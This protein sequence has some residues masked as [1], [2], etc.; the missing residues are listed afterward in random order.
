VPDSADVTLVLRL[1]AAAVL[2]A[3]IGYEREAAG[4]SAGLR[5]HMLVAMSA[6][7]FVVLGEQAVEHFG[8]SGRGRLQYDPLRVIQAVV[9]GIGFLGSGI[10]FVDRD[11]TRTQGLTT[12]A[13]VWATAGVGIA[14]GLGRFWAA[15]GATL[16]FLGVLR[17]LVRYDRSEG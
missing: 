1:L 7:F 15:L 14:A 9:I 6:A 11:R 2:A 5:T 17:L 13:S 12:A 8:T 16:L 3:L 4:K 10:I